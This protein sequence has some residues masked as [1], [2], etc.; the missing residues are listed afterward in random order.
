MSLTRAA[1][2]A[3]V[4]A[5]IANVIVLF[6]GKSL[7]AVPDTFKPL[8]IPPVILWSVLGTI[9][10]A[11]TYALVRRMTVNPNRIFVIVSVVVLVLSFIPDYAIKDLPPGTMFGG[12]TMG[13]IYLLMFMHV[14]AAV[15]IV[16]MLLKLAA[17]PASNQ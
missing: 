3:A 12:A 14:V 17:Q 9:G 1:L 7:I 16:P 11:L 2:L 13:A 6:V 5:S 10:A 8:S 4:A 15:I